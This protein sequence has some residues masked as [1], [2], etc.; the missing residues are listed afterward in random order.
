MND[1]KKHLVFLE[2]CLRE[3]SRPGLSWQ[4]IEKEV[5]A[6]PAQLPR[7]LPTLSMAQWDD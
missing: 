5:K 3:N 4:E 2:N 1:L 7:G 6:L